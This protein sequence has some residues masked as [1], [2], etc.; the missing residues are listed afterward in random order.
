MKAFW[1]TVIRIN[2]ITGIFFNF[3]GRG[4]LQRSTFS[5]WYSCS[6]DWNCIKRLFVNCLYCN[7]AELLWRKNCKIVYWEGLF[8]NRMHQKK[9]NAKMACKIWFLSFVSWLPSSM[10]NHDGKWMFLWLPVFRYVFGFHLKQC[11]SD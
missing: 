5:P 4:E 6:E 10:S 7:T 11:P 9:V 8:V 1:S 2:T 3:L